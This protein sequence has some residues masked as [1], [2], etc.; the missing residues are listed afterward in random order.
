MKNISKCRHKIGLSQRQMAA[1]SSLS[2]RTIQLLESGAHDPRLSTLKNLAKAVGYP[3]DII[4]HQLDL[5]FKQPEDSIFMIS[6]RILKDGEDSW[7]IW[8]FN[9]VDSFRKEKDEAHISLPP[10]QGL[11][12]KLNA[13]I[14]STVETLCEELKLDFP[15]WCSSIPM[16]K[17]PWFVSGIENLKAISIVESPIH[18]RKRNIFVLENFLARR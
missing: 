9:F 11:S 4:D 18:F 15:T 7:K 1:I 13:L 17:I 8:L 3:Q 2:F 5:I 16:L 10:V 6:K 14:A 12:Q